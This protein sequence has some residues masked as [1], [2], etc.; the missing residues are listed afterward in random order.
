MRETSPLILLDKSPGQLAEYRERYDVAFG[1]LRT[2]LTKYARFSGVPYGLDNGCFVEFY[3]QRWL[4]LVDEAEEDRPLFIT[5]P[6]VV[7]DAMRTAELYEHFKARLNGHPRMLV[8]QDGIERVP[9]PWR[10]IVGIFV[11]GSDRFKY[12]REAMACAIAARRLGKL[13]H[14]GRVNEDR[15][16]TNWLQLATSIDGSGISQR[17]HMLENVLEAIAGMHRKQIQLPIEAA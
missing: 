3:E 14:V 16:V 11:G 1:Q 5:V 4:R 12:S 13:V 9:I 6:D 17:D 15:R 2:P 10:E 7:G 8:I